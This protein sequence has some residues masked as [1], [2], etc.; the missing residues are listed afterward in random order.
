MRWVPDTTTYGAGDSS[1]S[2]RWRA[3]ARW[4][5][6]RLIRSPYNYVEDNP[7]GSV[8]PNGAQTYTPTDASGNPAGYSIFSGPPINGA[9]M[10]GSESVL[11]PIDPATLMKEQASMAVTAVKEGFN[12][13]AKSGKSLLS[14][15]ENTARTSS[16]FD[17]A[18]GAVAGV[19]SGASA[20]FGQLEIAEPLADASIASFTLGSKAALVSAGLAVV[21]R[22]TGTISTTQLT[23][24][25]MG[26]AAGFAFG[27]FID[28]PQVSTMTNVTGKFLEHEGEQSIEDYI[29]SL[30]P[31][32][33]H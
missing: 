23:A 12:Q 22:A 31:Q 33:T 28:V 1:V 16:T 10:H 26:T 29:N 3:I 27:E 11:L 24:Q 5:L 19:A 32:P 4:L 30:S 17:Y 9:T 2:I 15:V 20:A 7:T 14:F 8:D 18:V 6:G 21:Q 25:L 13:L